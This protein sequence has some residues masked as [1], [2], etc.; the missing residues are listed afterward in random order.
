MALRF[1]ALSRRLPKVLNSIEDA[2]VKRMS[3]FEMD[4]H[5]RAKSVLASVFEETDRSTMRTSLR[6]FARHA[7]DQA[8]QE[9]RRWLALLLPPPRPFALS[10]FPE[11]TAAK[12][13]GLRGS[14]KCLHTNST[15]ASEARFHNRDSGTYLSLSFE[16][17]R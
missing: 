13:A 16:W 2:Q 4:E 7:D 9:F 6:A 17:P 3:T 1:W 15:I 14:G 5:R 8:V 12:V 11:L 10:G